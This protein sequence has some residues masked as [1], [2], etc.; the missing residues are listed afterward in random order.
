VPDSLPALGHGIGLRPTHYSRLLE[1]GAAGVAWFEAISENFFELG[2]RP[3]AVLERVRRDV[4]VVLHGVALGIGSADPLSEEYLR[5]LERL[6]EHIEPAWVSD[7]LCWGSADGRYS[8]DL[9]PIVYSEE[10]LEHVVERVERVQSRLR[11]RLVLENIT[12]YLRFADSHIP[13]QEFLNELTRRTGAG[14]LLDV[15]NVYVNSRNL[16][17]DARAYL[18]ALRPD[19]VRQIHLAGHTVQPDFILDSHVGPVPDPVW[20]LYRHALRRLGS[21]PTLVEWD[22][23]VPEL[24]VVL[25]EARRA[26][27]I[28]QEELG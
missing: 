28:E 11:R 21:V 9:L 16:G 1:Q 6:I 5:S 18:D 26:R 13:E 15:N 17:F 24:D 2:G 20:E 22:E 23:A 8:H 7:H 10:A 25:G 19:S 3:R 27:A 12:A 4:P 14:L